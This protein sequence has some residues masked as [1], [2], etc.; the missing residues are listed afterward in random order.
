MGGS[1][2]SVWRR[3]NP[4]DEVKK[5]REANETNADEGINTLVNDYLAKQLV[6]CNDRNSDEINEL[7]DSIKDELKDIISDT[8]NILFGGSVQK[9][10]YVEGISDIDSLVCIDQSAADG[11]T[12]KEIKELIQQILSKKYGNENVSSGLLAVTIQVKDYEIQLLPAIRV[13]NGLKISSIDGQHWSNINTKSFTDILTSVN[14]ENNGIVV[15]TIKL[16][17]AIIKSLPEKQQLSGYHIE[18]LAVNIFRKYNDTKT[19][20][21][22]VKYFFKEA[23]NAVKSP[24]TDKTGQSL[25]VDDYLGPAN[26]TQRRIISVAL[27]RISRKIMNLD[28][29]RDQEFV[30]DS[31]SRLLGNDQ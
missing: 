8:I 26:S 2:S 4:A 9:N 12:P 15:P 11:K 14:K 20:K 10:T 5:I 6:H 21:E 23:V 7:L 28:A 29:V 25:H 22:M 1:G 31:W 24:I 30:I 16:V 13:G 18:S 27:D 3:I 17:K 19:Y